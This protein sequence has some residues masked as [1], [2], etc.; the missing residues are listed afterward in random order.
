MRIAISR[1]DGALLTVGLAAAL[2]TLRLVQAPAPDALQ[3]SLDSAS[4]AGERLPLLVVV[5]AGSPSDVAVG[6]PV[7]EADGGALLEVDAGGLT[8]QMTTDL[9][10]S[11]PG[12][13]IVIGGPAAVDE[14]TLSTLRQH[15]GVSVTRLA[16]ADRF[17]TAALVARSQFPGPVEQVR[18]LP[19][20]APAV[21]APTGDAGDAGSP[22]LLVS[23]DRVPGG[24]AAALRELEPTTIAVLGG[25]GAVSAGVL[26]RLQGFARRPLVQLP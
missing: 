9:S 20:D 6:R 16:G 7:A 11:R 13:V 14:V 18:V 3:S 2:L 25:R 21:P 12:R 10:R 15:T 22:V 4:A 1:L 23:R 8:P 26:E 24:T 17:E 5:A 19:D